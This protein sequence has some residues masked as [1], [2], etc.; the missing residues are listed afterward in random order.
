MVLLADLV[1]SKKTLYFCFLP[2]LV[3]VA[4]LLTPRMG[5]LNW[6]ESK[7]FLHEAFAS[8]DSEE[9]TVHNQ[10]LPNPANSITMY[11]P[12]R[13]TRQSVMVI[14]SDIVCLHSNPVFTIHRIVWGI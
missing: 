10:V 8:A 2:A 13:S 9:P 1:E 11:V 5:T 4:A 14:A 3:I 7:V 6:K 12:L